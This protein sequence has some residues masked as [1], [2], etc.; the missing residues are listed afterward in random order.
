MRLKSKNSKLNWQV[1]KQK[2]FVKLR[3]TT[4][5]EAEDNMLKLRA[6]T[7]IHDLGEL[8]KWYEDNEQKHYD[9]FKRLDENERKLGKIRETIQKLR[10][11]LSVFSG[12]GNV[13]NYVKDEI[14]RRAQDRIVAFNRATDAC[15]A[16]YDHSNRLLQNTC[17]PI[18]KI[19]ERLGERESETNSILTAKGV[20]N[21]TVMAFLGIIDQ[22]IAEILQFR[23]IIIQE[24]ISW[25]SH[26]MQRRSSSSVK[27][28]NTS[29][30]MRSPTVITKDFM[31][32]VQPPSVSEV[33]SAVY[34]TNADGDPME[35]A[36]SSVILTKDQLKLKSVDFYTVRE[37]LKSQ[38]GTRALNQDL[39]VDRLH[40][41]GTDQSQ[42]SPSVVMRRLRK[43]MKGPMTS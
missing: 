13:V 9:V 39:Q 2:I 30:P 27:D 11:D 12:H 21:L 14:A 3:A 37:S 5:K 41:N 22:R 40:R 15:K 20:T 32:Q 29:S 17:S 26:T 36:F 1:A 16:S 42:L 19:F 6:E 8:V 23:D 10:K 7:G 28:R 25:G 43:G 4:I 31:K 24:D 35:D 38:K 33:A 18:E 34:N